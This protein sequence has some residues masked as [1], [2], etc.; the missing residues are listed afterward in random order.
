MT[1]DL[2]DWSRQSVGN[3]RY[4]GTIH[5][6]GSGGSNSATYTI[7][8]SE[9]SLIYMLPVATTYPVLVQAIG[10]TSSFATRQC[11]F[12][13][14]AGLFQ[15]M[16]MAVPVSASIDSQWIVSV[17]APGVAGSADVYVFAS[18][19]GAPMANA[20]NPTPV[21]V[22]DGTN[23]YIGQQSAAHSM[24]VVMSSDQP[25]IPVGSSVFDGTNW[26]PLK[27]ATGDSLPQAGIPTSGGMVWNVITNAWDRQRS[28]ADAQFL[29]TNQVAQAPGTWFPSSLVN[30]GFRGVHV[31]T[32]VTATTGGAV[33]QP[34]IVSVSADQAS[35]A[36]GLLTGTAIGTGAHS[37]IYLYPGI[38]VTANKTASMILPMY[39]RVETNVNVGTATYTV[40]IAY[41]N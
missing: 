18:T 11:N 1:L 10:V 14:Y 16:P 6:L 30:P 8:P 15:N 40:T 36:D 20:A 3:V 17:S 31:T 2:P 23:L 21:A 9:R 24:P 29:M 19:D 35:D 41:L 4:L 7:Q 13:L 26:I 32:R 25:L 12:G 38:A 33:V 27:E 28:L 5:V 22:S 39:W 34:S 37:E